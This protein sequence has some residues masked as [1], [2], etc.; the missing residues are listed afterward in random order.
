MR[1]G[2]FT[3]A[4]DNYLPELMELT[5]PSIEQYS[6]KIG[7][8]FTLIKDRKF[9]DLSPTYEKLQIYELGQNNDFN[10]L[11][12]A[13]FSLNEKMYNPIPCLTLGCIGAW[14]QYDAHLTLKKDDIIGPTDD[15]VSTNFLVV[16]HPFHEIWKPFD[17]PEI[18]IKNMKRPFC[19]DEYCI[20]RNRIEMGVGLCPII[21]PDLEN[22]SFRH[23]NFNTDNKNLSEEIEATKKFL[24]QS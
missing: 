16:P 5:I 22:I 6:K 10:I 13:D 18:M 1:V 8:S 19:L 3:V 14:M 21:A 11:L 20:S 24:T 7:A 23:C 2:V 12:D 9:P 4:V 17:N 15:M